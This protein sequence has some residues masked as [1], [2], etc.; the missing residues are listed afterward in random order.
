MKIKEYGSRREGDV[1]GDSRNGEK[2]DWKGKG[3]GTRAG[4]EY[5]GDMVEREEKS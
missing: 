5:S 1:A 3:V 4:R 2:D